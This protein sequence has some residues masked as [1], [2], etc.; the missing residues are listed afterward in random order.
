MIPAALAVAG[1]IRS[2][3]S[4][5]ATL[6]AIGPRYAQLLCLFLSML[7]FLFASIKLGAR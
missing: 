6:G 3:H 2:I 1:L 4:A 5:A 7:A